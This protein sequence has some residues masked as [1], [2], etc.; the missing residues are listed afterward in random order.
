MYPARKKKSDA[1]GGLVRYSG[2]LRI[3]ST[4]RK[5]KA[6]PKA[7]FVFLVRIGADGLRSRRRRESASVGE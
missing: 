1:E 2:G 6:T 4:K 3:A 5:K 7:A